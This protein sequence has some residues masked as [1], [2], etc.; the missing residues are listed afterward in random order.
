[1]TSSNSPLD[2]F[3]VPSQTLYAQLEELQRQLF[4]LLRSP[5]IKFDDGVRRAL[6]EA[7]GIYRIFDP[8]EPDKTIRAGRTKTAAGG[9]RQRLYQN[10]LMG[11]QR[12]NLRAQLVAEGVCRDMEAAKQFIR[13]KLAAQFLVIE[14]GDD[15]TCLEHFILAVLKPRYCD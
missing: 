9:L 10:H 11:D 15:R 3:N 2:E 7:H 1:M 6:P 13:Q 8:T 12:G 14:N 5:A 4:R